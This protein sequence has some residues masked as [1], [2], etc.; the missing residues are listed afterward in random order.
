[1]I[2][3][4][5]PIEIKNLNMAYNN[6]SLYFYS[7]NNTA[8][9]Y[10]D[11][12][13][14]GL[15]ARLYPNPQGRFFFNFKPYVTALINTRNFEDRV[16][17]NINSGNPDSFM[18]NVT[19][20]TFLQRNVT[21]KIVFP[22]QLPFDDIKS[23]VI[24]WLAGVE[25]VG[26]KPDFTIGD[27]LV[28]SPFQ[29]DSANSYYLKYWQGYPFDMA[30]FTN[31]NSLTV[32]NET[33]LVSQQLN[34]IGFGTRLFFSDGRTDETLEDLIPLAEGY[35][36]LRLVRMEDFPQQDKYLTLEKVPYK[37]GVYLKWFNK[38]GGYSYWLF[39]NTYSIDR[40][41]KSLGELD[42]D[43]QNLSEAYTRSLTIGKESQETV[44][45]VAE[46]LTDDER[47]IVEGIL[48]SPKIYMFT[49]KPFSRNS[50]KDWVE[51]KLKTGSARLKNPR[52]PL[53]NFTFDLELPQR[54]TQML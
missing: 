8:P 3:F 33:N 42:Y 11:I 35:N 43:D 41:T 49:G 37:E 26:T 25:Q 27:L 5:P 31:T 17:T 2:I 40:T 45:I 18:Y 23:Y 38:Y 30:F 32:H 10:C 47:I 54:Y 16:V 21:F 7:T 44:K 1:M 19:A 46:L 6:Y 12:T 28:L 14:M 22:G 9:S 20:G 15:S 4:N 53:T 50:N 29:K 36:K 34:V 51:V 48:D 52:Q 13:A 24:S 39:E